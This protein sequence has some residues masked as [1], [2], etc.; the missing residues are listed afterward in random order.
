MILILDNYDS[1]TYNIYQI[2]A[3]QNEN[4]KVYRNNEITIEKI[5]DLNP[6][7]IIISHIYFKLIKIIFFILK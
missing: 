1:F 5:Y 7:K 4:T 6:E 3:E 2:V